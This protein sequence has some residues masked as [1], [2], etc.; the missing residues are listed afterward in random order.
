MVPSKRVIAKFAGT[1]ARN[2]AV[3]Y[4]CNCDA[5]I[6]RKRFTLKYRGLCETKKL[7]ECICLPQTGTQLFISPAFAA[8]KQY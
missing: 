3:R 2:A 8:K 4:F 6:E 7:A 1:A 5:V